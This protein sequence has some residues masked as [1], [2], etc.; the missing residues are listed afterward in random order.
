M[1]WEFSKVKNGTIQG[2]ENSGIEFFT[3]HEI[4]SLARE[5][6]QNSLDAADGSGKPVVVEFSLHEM[7]TRE[8]PGYE[9]YLRNVELAR[10]FWKDQESEKAIHFLDTARKTLKSSKL[11]VL[12]ISDYGTTGLS[13]PFDAQSSGSWNALVKKDG[14]SSKGGEQTGSFGIG[15][16]APFASSDLRMVFY[17]TLNQDGIRASQ[18]VSRFVTFPDEND[19]SYLA[20]GRGLFGE[21]NLPVSSIGALEKMKERSACGTDVFIFGFNESKNWKSKIVCEV[22]CNFLP[23]IEKENLIVRLNEREVSKSTL[24]QLIRSE[25]QRSMQTIKSCYQVLTSPDTVTFQNDFY[26]LGYFSLKLLS[27]VD[28]N[29]KIYITRT[30]GMKIFDKSGLYSG[31]L[32][33]SGILEIHGSKLNHF[34]KQLE[35][36]QHTKWIAS[37][38]KEDP[39]LAKNFLNKLYDW[40]KSCILSLIGETDQESLDVKGLSDNLNI[41]KE[42]GMEENPDPSDSLKN[43]FIKPAMTISLDQSSEAKEKARARF[44]RKLDGSTKLTGGTIGK[45]GYSAIRKLHGERPKK[46]MNKELHQGMPD[47]DGKDL[48][49]T[50]EMIPEEY[51][52]HNVRMIKLANSRYRTAF[53]LPVDVARGFIRMRSVGENGKSAKLAITDGASLKNC[54]HAAVKN[55]HLHFQNVR[56]GQRV[57][58]EFTLD[59]ERDLAM[60]IAIY[61]N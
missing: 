10:D 1:D 38:Y 33:F 12:R 4:K 36:P 24:D 58:V 37:R 53:T 26:G 9:R 39:E 57:Q 40:I 51:Y 43:K 17:R 49:A 8:I 14:G 31:G 34:F 6:C 13:D 46:R 3:G 52:I 5:I 21:E 16:N 32:P 2:V 20:S 50:P 54:S 60:E 19:P 29:N 45:D 42:E 61:E 47:R 59:C 7:K 23:A 22:L 11:K 30:S 41:T 25:D 18:G 56:A 44:Y 55:G 28:L 15:K 48:V 27:E 35:N